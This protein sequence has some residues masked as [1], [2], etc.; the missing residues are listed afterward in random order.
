MSQNFQTACHC[1]HLGEMILG[2][3]RS[4][5]SSACSTFS[6]ELREKL[7]DPT[8]IFINGNAAAVALFLVDEHSAIGHVKG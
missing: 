7:R 3:D 1:A 4:R 8:G 2:L 6:R 5:H